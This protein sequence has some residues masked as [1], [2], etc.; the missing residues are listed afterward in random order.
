MH[1]RRTLSDSYCFPGCKPKRI[2]HGI[3][4]DSHARVIS[5]LRRGKKRFVAS[6]VR[7]GRPSMTA[8]PVW[9]VISPAERLEY[10][11]NSTSGASSVGGGGPGNGRGWRFWP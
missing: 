7:L 2:V 10:T 3:F 9:F 8:R 6:A 5:L 1:K 11:S 4:G